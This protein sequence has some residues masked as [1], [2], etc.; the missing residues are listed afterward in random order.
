M[1]LC[2]RPFAAVAACA[3]LAAPGLTPAQVSTSIPPAITTPNKVESRIGPL[4]FKDGMPSKE[5]VAKIYDNLDFTHAFEAFVNTMQGVN[6]EAITLPMIATPS[7]PPTWRVVSLTADPTPAFARGTEL[8]I[9]SVAGAIVSPMP[10][11]MIAMRHA[12]SPQ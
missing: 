8:M 3:V 7:A 12:T 11:A 1:K 10:S 6:A 5:T 9:D 4:F 2:L